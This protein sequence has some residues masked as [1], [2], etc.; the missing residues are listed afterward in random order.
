MYCKYAHIC[1][2]VRHV[3]NYMH[4]VHTQPLASPLDDKVGRGEGGRG[5]ERGRWGGILNSVPCGM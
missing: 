5:G 2:Y 4:T 3:S 1:M